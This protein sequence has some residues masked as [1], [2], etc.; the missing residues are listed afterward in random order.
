[1]PRPAPASRLGAA[2][3]LHPPDYHPAVADV[4]IASDSSAIVDDIEAAIGGPD[5]T[6]RVVAAGIDVLPAAL[7][8]L[9]DLVV[10]D[11]QIG[12]MGAMA[13][14]LNLRLEESGERLDHIPILVLLDRRPDVFLARRSGADGWI[15]KPLDPI[16]LAKAAKLL[17]A[18]GDYHD[19][20]GRPPDARP[21]E[22]VTAGDQ[23]G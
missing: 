7:D 12:N 6:L 20:T 11:Q 10:L 21:A 5:T 15:M 19:D 18:G 14:S 9:P 3:G 23:V 1:M 4:L 16:R 13:C 22:P 2:S 17:L 8:R